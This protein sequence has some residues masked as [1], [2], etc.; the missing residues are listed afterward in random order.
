MGN[1]E[2]MDMQRVDRALSVSLGIPGTGVVNN[3]ATA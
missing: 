2:A 1:L 3:S